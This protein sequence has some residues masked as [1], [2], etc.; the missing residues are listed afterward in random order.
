MGRVA[1]ARV[2]DLSA[3][4]DGWTALIQASSNGRADIAAELV[5][6]GVDVNA[7]DNVRIRIS[8]AAARA[9]TAASL[10]SH[11]LAIGRRLGQLVCPHRMGSDAI[12]R[13]ILCVRYRRVWLH[14]YALL[15][16][17]TPPRPPSSRGLARTSTRRTTYVPTAAARAARV[18]DRCA[19]ACCSLVGLRS[20]SLLA[21]ATPSRPPS[22]CGSARTSTRRTTCVPGPQ[23]LVASSCHVYTRGSCV[24]VQVGAFGGARG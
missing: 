12:G 24:R 17:A 7:K 16:G 15:V 22:S 18:A 8:A 14:F 6:L 9:R 19:V 1:V 2:A 5:R 23:R 3:L 20:C 10:C 21:T 11:W 4:Q 13:L